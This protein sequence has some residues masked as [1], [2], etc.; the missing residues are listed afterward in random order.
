M[1]GI[2]PHRLPGPHYTLARNQAL[3]LMVRIPPF[4]PSRRKYPDPKKKG[5]TGWVAPRAG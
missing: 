1:L 3:K 2:N 4:D 5:A